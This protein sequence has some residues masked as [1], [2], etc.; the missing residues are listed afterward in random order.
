MFKE[1]LGK[2]YKEQPLSFRVYV[3]MLEYWRRFRFM[4][5]F[6]WFDLLVIAGG[7][8]IIALLT[9]LMGCITKVVEP[10]DVVEPDDLVGLAESYCK[11]DPT[12]T[13]GKVY[14]FPER[15]EENNIGM[16]ELC[17][18]WPD[19]TE[20]PTLA[21]AEAELGPSILSPDP[22]F[23]SANLCWWQCPSMRGCNSYS[24]CYC[25]VTIM[26]DAGVPD[27]NTLDFPPNRS[28]DK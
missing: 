2:P 4:V 17:V 16:M 6:Y 11:T 14:G 9:S 26:P 25:P 18:P 10:E 20:R 1:T 27:M 21:Q 24:G 23:A 19:S 28:D 8:G 7:I 13:C 22:R 3:T 15:P 5:S 12:L